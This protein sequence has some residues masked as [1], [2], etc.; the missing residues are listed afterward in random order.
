MTHISSHWTDLSSKELVTMGRQVFLISEVL[1][2]MMALDHRFF[3]N[4]LRI[5]SSSEN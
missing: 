5:P 3:V 2:S 4:L 1:Q